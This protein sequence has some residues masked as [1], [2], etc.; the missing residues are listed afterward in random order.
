MYW[1]VKKN[2]VATCSYRGPTWKVAGIESFYKDYYE[3]YEEAVR[4]ASILS[5]YN[6]AGFNVI[7]IEE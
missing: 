2:R 1:I 7:L 4:L 5:E 3:D 6:L